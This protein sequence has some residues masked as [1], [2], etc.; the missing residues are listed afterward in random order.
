LRE[1]ESLRDRYGPGL[2]EKKRALVAAL[3]RARLPSAR[4]V[5]RFHEALAWLRA[6]PDDAELAALV[7]R[8]LQAFERRGDLRRWR[9]ELADTGVAGTDLFYPF[10]A[11]TARWM[12]ERWPERLHVDWPA[13]GDAERELLQGRLAL[14]LHPAEVPALDEGGLELEEWVAAARGPAEAS[15]AFL[16]RSCAAF[17]ADPV[18]R[19]RY[20]DELAIPCRLAP[21]P[22]T[23]ARTRDRL[24]GAPAGYQSAPLDRGRPDLW[25]ELARPPRSIR[26]VGVR[27]GQEVV[28]LAR[29][30]MAT[31]ARDLDAF[32]YGDP[33]DV[34]IADCG[35]GLAFAIVGLLPAHRLLLEAVYGFLTLKNG[36]PIGYVLVSALNRSSE[37]AYNVFD[38]Y[39]GGEAARVYGRV[40]A[41]TRAL[42][43]SEVFTVY[44]Y[45]LGG[46]GNDEGLDSGAWWFYQKLGFRAHDRGVLALMR[47]ELARMRKSPRHRS[48]RRTLER[49]AQHNVYLE[50]GKPRP[51]VIGE[52]PTDGVGRAA[53]R[54]LATRFGGAG[55]AA[56]EACAD[57]AA[58]AL[59]AGVWR[60]FRPDER[61]AF[62]AW[63]PVVLALSGLARWSAAERRALV[64]VIRAKGG[65]RESDFVH[66]F[67]AHRRLRRALVRLAER[68]AG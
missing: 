5:L 50:R 45:Q 42:F 63:A 58:R 2:G 11:R 26:T 61:R 34:R 40:L 49:L 56:A 66:R 31:R 57:E 21:G 48:S 53:T 64:Q 59:G 32:C 62:A 51:D 16:A 33:R 20:Q 60:R 9:A 38:T 23:P 27:R 25:A 43:G 39:R 22:D 37:I 29:K 67:D 52:L 46:Y 54:L 6:Y 41:T 55:R 7:E 14:L 8:A 44:P 17:A 35:D 3:A 15:G 1:L 36:V 18:A 13:L 47:R 30:A 24:P 65:R 10:F 68:G 19:D 4:A 12:A 28:D